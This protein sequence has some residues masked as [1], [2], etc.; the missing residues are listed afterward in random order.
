MP[1]KPWLENQGVDIDFPFTNALHSVR[2]RRIEYSLRILLR[3]HSPHWDCS[4]CGC[5]ILYL[6]SNCSKHAWLCVC[7][8]Q[9][10]FWGLVQIHPWRPA[11]TYFYMMYTQIS[12]QIWKGLIANCTEKSQ[13]WN[14]VPIGRTWARRN[15][16]I[17]HSCTSLKY[18][19][20]LTSYLPSC[21]FQCLKD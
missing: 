2:S 21:P 6:N 20:S 15:C 18:H 17:F 10:Y 9:S 12:L 8:L 5:A 11:Q 3:F 14:R 16:C 7:K 1:C 4:C 19:N 13:R